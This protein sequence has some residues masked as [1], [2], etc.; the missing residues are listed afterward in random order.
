MR[1]LRKDVHEEEEASAP[2][3]ATNDMASIS[4]ALQGVIRE[5]ELKGNELTE[6]L[7]E[8]E[9]RAEEQAR[10]LENL[11]AI[12]LAAFCVTNREGLITRNFHF[13][14]PTGW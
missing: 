4:R 13:D 6:S 10:I 8:A 3:V 14:F 5:F 9:R 2:R 7:R 1:L 11:G 12:L